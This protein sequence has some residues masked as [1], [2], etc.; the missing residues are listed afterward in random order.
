[1]KML[2]I[3]KRELQLIARDHSILLTVLIAPLLYAFFYGSIYIN[4][5]ETEVPLAIV[6][7]DQSNLSHLLATQLDNTPVVQVRQAFT[8]QEA[9]QLLNTAECQGYLYFEKGMEK[10]VLSLRPAHAVLAVNASR[11]LPSSDLLSQV[12]TVCLTISAAVRLQ[13]FEKKGMAAAIAMRETNPLALDYRPLFNERVSYGAYLLPGLLMLILQQ[14]LLIGLSASM[15]GEREKASWAQVL[16]ISGNNIVTALTGKGAFYFILFAAYAF[17]F[18]AVNFFLLQ[19]P[20]RG[21]T[22]VL[23]GALALFIATL[24]PLGL[25]IG[26]CF[27]SQLLAV[28]VMGF[29][30]YPFFLLSGYAW[31]YE[32]LPPLL[33]GISALIPTTPFL[34]AYTIIVQQGGSLLQALP[35][36]AHLIALWGIYSI[37]LIL[38]MIP[39]R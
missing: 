31:P 2:N 26:S 6:D 32:E 14:T 36:L 20:L 9:Q 18:L 4:K 33:Q 21:N 27:R 38:R 23:A 10:K 7:E 12:T 13:Y 8:L 30:T 28:Q 15:A 25:N 1:M 34:Q 39:Q 29:S 3:I 17:F 11:F 37:I 5:E 22:L 16:Q 35:A 19:L 24:I